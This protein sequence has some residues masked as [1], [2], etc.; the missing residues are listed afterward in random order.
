[1]I[2][3]SPT[4]DMVAVEAGVSRA[5]VSRVV[6]GSTQV[7][8][9]VVRL[10]NEAIGRLNYIPNRAA[11]SLA[12]RQ[13]YAV[14][15]LV[16][17]NTARFFGDP[18]FASI[19]Q[20]ISA[21]LEPTDYV[22]NLL[23]ARS[24]PHGKTQRYLAG[25]NVDGA[26]VVS[27]HA[28]DHHLTALSRTLPVVFGGRP[29]GTGAAHLYSVDVDNVEGAAQATRHLL[30]RGRRRIGTITGPMDMPAGLD[31]LTGWRRT[32]RAAGLA[33]DALEMSDFTTQGG[34]SAMGRLL[35]RFDD[36]D[37]VFVSNDLMARGALRTLTARGRSVPSDL[38]LVAYDDG[39]AA[40]ES[41]PQ[42]TTIRQPSHQMGCA[43]TQMLLDI[44]AGQ[45]PPDRAL[46]LPT[47]LVVRGTT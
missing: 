8:P 36:L 41:E 31:R 10:V 18:F 32:L 17:E 3:S 45:A 30:E 15:L 22:L 7:R 25:G 35:D 14:A 9:D 13:T 21:S 24:D 37:G 40:V 5:T 28:D 33:D 44:L 6:N 47:E 43:M 23:V 19:V 27:H 34:A 39:P 42:L 4:L 20:G 2:K 46:L 29:N 11:R 1:M 26:L 38:A 12:S 16:P